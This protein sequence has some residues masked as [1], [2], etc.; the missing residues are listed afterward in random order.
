MWNDLLLAREWT[1][2]EHEWRWTR[3]LMLSRP[4]EWFSVWTFWPENG[5]DLLGWYVN[6]E[7]PRRRS[8]T[9]FD[10][11]DLQLDIVIAPDGSW[12]YKDEVEY[13][14][15]QRLGLITNEEVDRVQDAS[16]RVESMLASDRWWVEWKDWAP[17]PS[18]PI[19]ELPEG[20]DRL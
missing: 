13:A 7:E 8:H 9:G 19:P 1:L 18:W 3:V 12:S 20:W 17:D 16:A 5:D 14:E 10:T 2:H 4:G 6:F 11:R 15:M